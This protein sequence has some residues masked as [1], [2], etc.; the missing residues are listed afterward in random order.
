MGRSARRL[1]DMR[2][3]CLFSGALLLCGLLLFV[4]PTGA[5]WLPDGTPMCVLPGEQSGARVVSDGSH[6]AIVVWQ[7]GRSGAGNDIYAQRVDM[8]G[9]PLWTP[10]GVAICT[11]ASNQASP[12]I[13]T[14]EAGGAVITWTD[15]RNGSDHDIYAQR[16]N[17]DGQVLWTANGVAVCTATNYQ[18]A[19]SIAPGGGGGVVIAWEDQR[20]GMDYDIYA[21]RV[22]GDGSI[23]W[24]ADG[25][26]I[27]TS[28][29]NQYHPKVVADGSYGAIIT[30]FD[31]R[32]VYSD[33]YA[34]R[35]NLAGT[36]QWTAD[37]VVVC[38]ATYD[39]VDAVL[40]TDGAGGAIIAW[41]DARNGGIHD[42]YAQRMTS[43]GT[44]SWAANGVA[45]CTATGTQ[46]T[47]RIVSD[48]SGGAV[49]AWADYRGSDGD[50]YSQRLSSAGAVQWTANGVLICGA[51]DAQFG[52][53]LTPNGSGGAIVTW[54]DNRQ[55]EW[56]DI[57]AQEVISSGVVEWSTNGIA[58]CSA[59][60]NQWYPEITT[61]GYGGAIIAWQDYR[62]GVSYDVYASRVDGD[63][64]AGWTACGVPIS[65]AAFSQTNVRIVSDGGQGGIIV[66]EDY[67]NGSAN[68]D[69]Y[70][71]RV[72]SDGY[73]LWSKNGVPISTATSYQTG[74]TAAPDG[75]GGVLVAWE[76]LRNGSYDV[77]AQRGSSIQ[78]MLWRPNGAVVCSTTANT[79][80][81]QIASDGSGGAIVVW[82][83]VVGAGTSD[84]YAQRLGSSGSQMWTAAGVVV[85]GAANHQ[86][87]PQIIPD[88]A[89]GA[90]VAWY[91][92]RGAT[93]DVYAQRVN[94]NGTPL[95]AANGVVVSGAASAQSYPRIASDGAG[96]AIV[97]WTDSRNGNY[98][99]YAQRVNASGVA[100]WTTDGI[101]VCTETG[102]QQAPAL[103]ADGA[104]G[105]IVCWQDFR[106]GNSDIYAQ[107]LNASGVAQWTA[108]GVVAC[109][110]TGAQNAPNMATDGDYGAVISWYDGRSGVTPDIYA[111]RLGSDG[112]VMWGSDGIAICASDQDDTQAVLVNSMVG[113]A[114]VAWTSYS[115][116]TADDVYALSTDYIIAVPE[117]LVPPA[118]GARLAELDQNFPNPFNPVTT[119]AFTLRDAARVRLCVYDIAGRLVRVLEEGVFDAGRREVVWD[120][121]DGAGGRVASGVYFCGLEVA[122]AAGVAETK[123]MVIIR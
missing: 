97:C 99:I 29:G 117:E 15:Y 81:P 23:G 51:A 17:A 52:P 72:F 78:A 98:D 74:P 82:E 69:I 56:T 93:V 38:S 20:N 64:N 14:D 48:G 22:G 84:I 33:I 89:G 66:W 55:L 36:P 92:M 59:S 54:H 120:G 10:E 43:A 39:Q 60:D 116:T 91:D 110:A 75:S 107:R 4:P 61:D 46:T 27:C 37:G 7:D 30:W 106:S 28:A 26:P 50:I 109:A 77:Y 6:G 41:Q 105:V 42:V 121:K 35:V 11:A 85:C 57:Y 103:M 58:I 95:W 88:G 47:P 45:V 73:R 24:Q 94:A 102:Q 13:T 63:G 34:Q 67:R 111:Q 101:G 83:N 71:Q 25:R 2:C 5:A 21:Q 79:Y 40:T 32:T 86:Q 80:M 118:V 113:Q 8:D 12:E 62:S 114:I 112:D 70:G 3:M 87:E 31:Y 53:A 44:A 96:G 108:G 119:I 122:G 76:D 123:K 18:F 115:T 1:T 19:L 90:I 16:V 9:N 104:G 100:Q 68:S 65:T 49:M